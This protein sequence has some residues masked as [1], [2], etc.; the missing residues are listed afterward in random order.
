MLNKH[1]LHVIQ[2]I[3]HVKTSTTLSISVIRLSLRKD[4]TIH[5]CC[6]QPECCSLQHIHIYIY[7]HVSR[8]GDK[9]GGLGQIGKFGRYLMGFLYITDN[10][11]VHLCG[12]LGTEIYISKNFTGF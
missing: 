3:H 4:V 9:S 6:R 1:S 5:S 12:K 8:T 11:L 10:T 7:G 2:V